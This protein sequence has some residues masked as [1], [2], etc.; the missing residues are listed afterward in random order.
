MRPRFGSRPGPRS[1]NT[2]GPPPD[3]TPAPDA[4]GLDGPAH[5]PP[6]APW[7]PSRRRCR[8]R[9]SGIHGERL[10]R[11]PRPGPARRTPTPAPRPKRPPS[12]TCCAAGC[13]RPTWPR[14]TGMSCASPPRQRHR[15]ARPRALLVGHRLAPLRPARP[16]RRAP[17]TRRRPTPSP[18]RPCWAGRRARAK[19]PTWSAAS[20]TPSRRTARLHR[21]PPPPRRRP[22]KPTSSSPPSSPCCSATRCTPPP[23]AAR[24]SPTPKSGRYSPE[25]R[26]SF[27][28]HWLAVDRSVLATDSAWTE[29]GR[30]CPRPRAHA[31]ARRPGL[32]PARGT[33]SLPLHPWQARDIAERPAVAALLD[34]GLLRDLGPHG[35]PWHPTSSVRTVHRPGAAAMLKLSLGVRITNSRRENLRKELHRGVEVHRLLRSRARRAVAGRP[36][37]LRHRPRPGLARGRHPERRSAGG[38]RRHDPPQPVRPSATTPSAS[39]ALTAPQAHAGP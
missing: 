35:G 33:A 24:A 16:A 27:P 28:L 5:P 11:A 17:T 7:R 39:P 13:A 8:A 6:A 18:S 9:R 31:P 25:L 2:R 21:R 38:A 30:T 23:R 3:P 15:A 34:A 10:H 36:P 29:S 22:P 12:R 37:L 32:D 20:P 1:T 26:G 14:P 4:H 19:A